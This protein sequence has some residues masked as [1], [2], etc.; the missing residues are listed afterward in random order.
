[1]TTE[2]SEEYLR[3]IVCASIPREFPYFIETTCSSCHNDLVLYDSLI[4]SEPINENSSDIEETWYDEWLCPNCLDGII[5]DWPPVFD[6]RDTI[7]DDIT[8]IIEK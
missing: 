1:M 8:K 3:R 4:Q 6:E 2:F 5:M 7:P